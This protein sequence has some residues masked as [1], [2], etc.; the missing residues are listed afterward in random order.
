MIFLR[1]RKGRFE[2]SDLLAEF[3]Y[4]SLKSLDIFGDSILARKYYKEKHPQSHP[5]RFIC[6]L[7]KRFPP[8]QSI[9]KATS[10][11]Y[12]YSVLMEM[13]MIKLVGQKGRWRA[14]LS[15]ELLK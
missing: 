5:N 11:I 2:G 15:L 14:V 1:K 13:L 3:I 12:C 9:S 4:A 10:L 7:F 8:L 6:Q